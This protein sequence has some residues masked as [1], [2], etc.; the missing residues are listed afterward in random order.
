MNIWFNRW[1]SQV[2]HYIEKIRNNPDG[3]EFKIY[4]S[5]PN[6]Y[7]TYLPFCDVVEIEPDTNGNEYVDWCLKFCLRHGIDI[8]IPRKANVLVSKNLERFEQIG[9]KVLV[10]ND[11]DLMKKMDNKAAM[12]EELKNAGIVPIP[13]YR[14][15][16]NAN[17]FKEAYL[18]LSE[19][20]HKVCFKPVV[21]EGAVGFRIIDDKADN[22]S[23]LFSSI[24]HK[25]SFQ[26]AYKMLSQKDHFHEIML[27][28]YLDG[29][30]YSI[31]CL[32]YDGK[33]LAAVPRKKAGG[34]IY[35]L[36]NSQELIE[37][38]KKFTEKYKLSYIYNIQV[39]YKDGI[40]KLLEVNPRMSGGLHMT[41]LS[42]INYPYEALKLLL[43]EEPKILYP[44]YGITLSQLEQEFIFK[45]NS[46]TKK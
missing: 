4:G 28:E 11:A 8:F 39:K 1:F 32:G 13:D 44:E 37:V 30:E 43:G 14:I 36:E 9:V 26:R 29:F 18:E 5:H 10:C 16:T 22:I 20:G 27:L 46:I 2:T 24:D 38:A 34:R 6:P 12:Y 25:I 40:P 45:E 3:K 31:D 21:G 35:E 19:K 17:D 7:A 42:G 41:C 15:V 23:Q 33:L